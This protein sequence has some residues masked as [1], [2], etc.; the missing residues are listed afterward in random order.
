MPMAAPAS[1]SD[2]TFRK[3]R[4]SWFVS[5]FLLVVIFSMRIMEGLWFMIF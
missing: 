2:V 4:L 5:S 1:A 3:S